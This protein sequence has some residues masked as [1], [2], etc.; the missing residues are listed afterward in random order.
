M[1][2]AP[3]TC[4]PEKDVP[5]ALMYRDGSIIEVAARSSDQ[6]CGCVDSN[7]RSG[8]VRLDLSETGN[9]AARAEGCRL[10]HKDVG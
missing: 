10:A 5:F 8:N 2:A 7:A 3:A 4:G 9:R 1:A 6:A